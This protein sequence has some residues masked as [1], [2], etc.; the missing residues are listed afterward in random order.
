[1][2]LLYRKTKCKR[3]TDNFVKQNILTYQTLSLFSAHVYNAQNY[4]S[5]TFHSIL[6]I[7]QLVILVRIK[8][9]IQQAHMSR[10]IVRA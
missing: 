7:N 1:M 3:Q 10:F 5:H 9:T 8:P 2:L 4:D 6:L